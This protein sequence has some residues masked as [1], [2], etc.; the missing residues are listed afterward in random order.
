[1]HR[2]LVF[3]I[4][5]VL[6]NGPV[7]AQAPEIL[8]AGKAWELLGEGYQLTSDSAVDPFR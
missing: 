6:E 8:V 7:H 1:M 3:P 2:L 4:L 5:A